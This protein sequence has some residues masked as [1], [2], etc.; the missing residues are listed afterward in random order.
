MSEI[1]GQQI[2][3]A[4]EAKGLSR[5]DLAKKIGV[6]H[7]SISHV[8]DR[9]SRTMTR[10]KVIKFLG[11]AESVD[12]N[13]K[14]QEVKIDEGKMPLSDPE[15]PRLLVSAALEAGVTT[16]P[17]FAIPGYLVKVARDYNLTLDQ[18]IAVCRIEAIWSEACGYVPGESTD[19]E[20]RSIIDGLLKWFKGDDSW[21]SK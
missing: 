12:R 2:K 21:Q 17:V 14:V 19:N 18:T 13:G 4:R 10:D 9:G 8:E 5:S 7:V 16:P 11:L 20:W 15:D 6:H 1:T 3:E